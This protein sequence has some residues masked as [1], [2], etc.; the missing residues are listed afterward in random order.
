MREYLLVILTG[1]TITYLLVPPVKSLAVMIG[2]QAPVRDRDVHVIPTPR[3]GGLAM[4]GGMVGALLMAK[5]LPHMADVFGETRTAQALLLAGGLIVLVGIA[6]D[7]WDIDALT[8]LAGQVAASGILIMNGVQLTSL[9]LLSGESILLGPEYGVPLTVLIIVATINAVNFIDGLDGLAAGVVG[10]A[11]TALFLIGYR[12][13]DGYGL[14]IGITILIGPTLMA[15]VLVGICFGFLAHNFHPARIFMG[16]TGSMLIGLL[17][18]AS[19]IQLIS[20]LDTDVAKTFEIIPLWL[21]LLLIP[22]VV[23]V[24]FLDM[25]LA[26]LRRTSN[27]YSPFAPDKMHLHHRLLRL[28][29][30]HRRSVVIMYGW[31]GLLGA[32]MF[33]ISLVPPNSP[34]YLRGVVAITLTVA[35]MGAFLM[36]GLP[37]LKSRRA[38]RTAEAIA[39]V[40]AAAAAHRERV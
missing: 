29:H 11:G 24:P 12:I 36:V 15:A 17:I 10:I 26:V 19:T 18:S 37:R 22:L 34:N 30:S 8:K 13:A 38:V 2:A 14:K 35:F 3:L 1:I 40:E 27:G 5:S 28:G 7:L 31:V 39:K 32:C 23:L 4:F 20:L 16:D 33:A 6:D 9:P 25:L 21:P